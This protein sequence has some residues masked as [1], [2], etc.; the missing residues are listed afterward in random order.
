VKAVLSVVLENGHDIVA[1]F[2]QEFD[3]FGA[4]QRRV[5]SIE[6]DGPPATL[7]LT[8]LPGKY[9]FPA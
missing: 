5:E 3:R 7:L 4:E 8:D 1:P 2:H 6:Q 9:R